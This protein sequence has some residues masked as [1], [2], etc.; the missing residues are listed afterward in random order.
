M[1]VFGWWKRKS[2]ENTHSI[3]H[4]RTGD[5]RP[6]VRGGRAYGFR[7]FAGR[8]KIAKDFALLLKFLLAYI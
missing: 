5:L 7:T 8:L 3:I 2:Q 1:N 6:Y 4:P